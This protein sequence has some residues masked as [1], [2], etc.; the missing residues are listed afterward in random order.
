MLAMK[1]LYPHEELAQ[2][3]AEVALGEVVA[4]TVP[5]LDAQRHL[6]VMTKA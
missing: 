3:P 2:L 1:G 6:V 5:G 4:L